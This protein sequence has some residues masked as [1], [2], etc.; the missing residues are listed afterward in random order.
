MICSKTFV[1]E[2]LNFF[3]KETTSVL[4]CSISLAHMPCGCP[5]QCIL[6]T[7]FASNNE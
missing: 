3:G 7:V 2:I 6:F 5:S 4:F 1:Y